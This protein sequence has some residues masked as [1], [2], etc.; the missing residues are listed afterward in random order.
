MGN[1]VPNGSRGLTIV[2]YGSSQ[3]RNSMAPMRMAIDALRFQ[4]GPAP[5]EIVHTDLPS[6]DFLALF[7][8]LVSDWTKRPSVR[9]AV[10]N[11]RR[12]KLRRDQNAFSN[13]MKDRNDA[14]RPPTAS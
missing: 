11:R 3:G 13:S 6:N 10:S 12:K 5:I 2:E 7:E 4:S 14:P 9:R 8:A 1:R